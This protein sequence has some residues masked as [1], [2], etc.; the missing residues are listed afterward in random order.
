MIGFWLWP[1]CCTG[2]RYELGQVLPRM[3]PLGFPRAGS[4]RETGC[5]PE[6]TI[7][8][9][10]ALTGSCRIMNHHLGLAHS[11]VGRTLAEHPY[12]EL[13]GLGGKP[14]VRVCFKTSRKPPRQSD[15]I[16]TNYKFRLFNRSRNQTE[17]FRFNE[18]TIID[19]LQLR[20]S[21]ECF[22]IGSYWLAC[23]LSGRWASA[24]LVH[25]GRR[26]VYLPTINKS[27]NHYRGSNWRFL[28]Y[29]PTEPAYRID[30]HAQ[31]VM[32]M[33]FPIMSINVV[34]MTMVMRMQMS[35]EWMC[36]LD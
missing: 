14:T 10:H 36:L 17:Y 23:C 34:A 7:H 32:M 5:L 6:A 3:A 30:R 8:N 15:R 4:V 12:D 22:V 1:I 28:P 26:N 2:M 11:S 27:H 13:K 35:Y 21:M 25:T 31:S 18:Q 33:L 24:T 9:T 19:V 29:R 20:A 16:V